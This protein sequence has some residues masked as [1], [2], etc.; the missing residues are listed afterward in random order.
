MTNSELA[1]EI[2]R[3][4]EEEHINLYHSVSK[5]TVMAAVDKLCEVADELTQ[6]EF[7][8]E[9]SKIFAMFKDAH[10]G[11]LYKEIDNTDHKFLYLDSKLYIYF[12]QKY[13]QVKSINKVPVRKMIKDM[14]E[15]V[16]YENEAWKNAMLSSK[17]NK[18]WCYKLIGVINGEPVLSVQTNE[19]QAISVGSRHCVSLSNK[20]IVPPAKSD[21]YNFEIIDNNILL[22]RYNNCRN[23]ENY[24]MEQFIEDIKATAHYKELSGIILDLR[25]NSGGNDAIVR[26]LLKCLKEFNLPT[27]TLISD[28][29][30]S[31]GAFAAIDAKSQL[32]ATLIGQ[33]TGGCATLYGNYS[34]LE[35]NG[36]KF[37]VSTK[38]F[39]KT[40]TA[41][42]TEKNDSYVFT[43]K[44]FD[45]TNIKTYGKSIEP[46][47]YIP[48]TINDLESGR[49]IAMETAK[50]Y[51]LKK[52][53]GLCKE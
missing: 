33:P 38:F 37:C 9:M 21:F 22:I 39:D 50:N 20:H 43:K 42:N 31:S 45:G 44:G 49:D 19:G 36:N 40:Y 5:Q 46:D 29:T 48:V 15:L 23:D 41:L 47:I 24:N 2:I 17:F 14:L 35:V 16:E 13:H 25:N 26:P 4:A 1:K 30:F 32:N 12:D 3:V 27:A 53:L 10:T 28:T 34:I 11:Y 6:V 51:I 18:I 8:R 7:D 52:S